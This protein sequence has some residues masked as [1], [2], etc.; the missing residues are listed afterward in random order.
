YLTAPG[1][2]GNAVNCTTTYCGEAFYMTISGA[3]TDLFDF[4]NNSCPGSFCGFGALGGLTLG[5]DGNFYGPT[6]NGGAS[7][8]HG[9]A[10]K[11]TPTGVATAL[12][13]F[14]GGSDGSR[15]NGALIQGTNGTFYG[16]TSS[17]GTGN[18]TAYSITSSGVFNTLH[19][20]TGA[21]G[22]NV[23]AKLVQGTDG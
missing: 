7:G 10:F 14:T 18:S 2:D 12:D 11:L 1:G 8:D 20:F 16:T 19:T 9:T 4:S 15:P 23:Y 3:V 13:N 6:Y 17:G 5:T 22:Q 21:D